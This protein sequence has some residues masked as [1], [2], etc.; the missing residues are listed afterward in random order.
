VREK[1]KISKGHGKMECLGASKNGCG[2][3]CKFML[4]DV[5]GVKGA[6]DWFGYHGG[7]IVDGKL[8]LDIPCDKLVDSKCSIYEQRPQACK[9]FVPGSIPECPLYKEGKKMGEELKIVHKQFDIEEFK[10][11]EDNGLVS[12]EGYANV[13]GKKD[14][15]GDIPTVFS[16]LRDYVYELKDF[17]RNPDHDNNVGSIAG[18]FNEKLGGFIGEDNIG[19]K[20]KA[21]FSN[22][23]YPLIAHARTVYQEGHGKALSIGGRWYF[24]DKDNPGNLTY[25]EIFEISLVGVGADPSALTKHCPDCPKRKG[26]TSESLE[27]GAEKLAEMLMITGCRVS[28]SDEERISI[29]K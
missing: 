18:S 1:K 5:A 28:K 3:C 6:E 16:V 11:V 10:V 23:D 19:L 25:A 2:S 26:I 8:R 7:K 24:E 22:S 14:R 20:F 13:K 9:D 15:Y 17:K 21:V 29:T 4:L 27:K 12:I